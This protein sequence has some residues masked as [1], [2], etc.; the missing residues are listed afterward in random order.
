MK[1]YM[2][3]LLLFNLIIWLTIQLSGQQVLFNNGNFVTHPGSGPGGSDYSLL[4]SPL[5]NYGFG[6]QYDAGRRVADDF[7][8][9]GDGWIIDSIVFFEYQTGSPTSTTFTATYLQIWKGSDLVWGDLMTNRLQRS[10]WSG[11]YRGD[12]FQNSQRPIMRNTCTTPSLSLQPGTYN[13][14]WQADGSLSS[15]PWCVPVTINGSLTTG[16]AQGYYD[17]EWG[18]LYG[19]TLDLFPQGLPFIVYGRGIGTPS[20]ISINETYTFAEPH[21]LYSYKIIGLPGQTNFSVSSIISGTPG[22]NWMAFRDN[23]A[24]TDYMKGYDGSSNFN[25]QPGNAFWVTSE[26]KIEVKKTVGAVP[27]TA[28][29]T[30]VIPVNAGSWTL[31]S[32]PFENDVKWEDIRIANGL[33]NSQVI[34]DWLGYWSNSSTLRT[35]KGYYFLAP[36]WVSSLHIPYDSKKSS[37]SYNTNSETSNSLT[38]S[39]YKEEQKSGSIQV[40]FHQEAK[41]G[42]DKFDIPIPSGDFEKTGIRILPELPDHQRNRELFLDARSSIGDGQSYRIR[43]TNRSGDPLRLQIEGV[44]H[45]SSSEIF[46]V[47]PRLHKKINLKSAQNLDP[48]S[49]TEQMTLLIGNIE[50]INRESDQLFSNAE[51]F[52]QCLPNPVDHLFSVRFSTPVD[53]K[54]NISIYDL[55]GR[56]LS[57]L[58]DGF[59]EAGYHEISSG[60]EFLTSGIYLCKMDLSP[61]SGATT[62][63]KVIRLQKR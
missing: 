17:G 43:F 57:T 6:N 19:D 14:D 55:T 37:L 18:Y 10:A 46:L 9:T 35:G 60:S 56:R 11:C 25:F 34:W 29:D 23:G 38:L 7:T 39:L 22:Q 47:I 32:N 3:S 58:L 12:D 63:H 28:W 48:G 50:Y 51:P 1:T 24:S 52:F 20:N 16:D 62:I 13:I 21:S 4:M 30:Y 36:S 41:S 33:D 59:I 26:N 31:I 40:L 45:F 5:S 8:V 15:G 2:K 27:L 42:A 44:E 53:T 49:E 61:L 54:A